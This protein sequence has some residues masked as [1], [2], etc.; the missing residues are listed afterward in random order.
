LEIF[1][2]FFI[3]GRIIHI[4]IIK[5]PPRKRKLEIPKVRMIGINETKNVIISIMTPENKTTS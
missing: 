5:T 3:R 2:I 4:T 1:P